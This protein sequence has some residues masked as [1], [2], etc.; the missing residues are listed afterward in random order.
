MDKRL[1]LATIHKLAMKQ[2]RIPMVDKRMVF[3]WNTN[4]HLRENQPNGRYKSCLV[5]CCFIYLPIT[6]RTAGTEAR[7]LSP[8]FI[9]KNA[10][11][12]SDCVLLLQPCHLP[13]NPQKRSVL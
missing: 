9:R 1:Y 7:P 2:G 6:H 10:V 4:Q 12:F 3:V 8:G 13:I 5:V 11:L